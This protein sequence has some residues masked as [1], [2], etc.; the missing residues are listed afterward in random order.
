MT[1]MSTVPGGTPR[2]VYRPSALADPTMDWPTTWTLASTSG[3]AVPA[4]VILPLMVACCACA[5]AGAAISVAAASAERIVLLTLHARVTL[6][7]SLPREV[8]Q[9]T[10]RATTRD[11]AC[12]AHAQQSRSITTSQTH[13]SLPARTSAPRHLQLELT[14][15]MSDRSRALAPRRSHLRGLRTLTY[16]RANRFDDLTSKPGPVVTSNCRPSEWDERRLTRW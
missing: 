11:R 12:A 9:H 14:S 8:G 3:C 1:R 6:I 7:G 5:T 13:S 2:S 16:P 10:L 4:A 15:E